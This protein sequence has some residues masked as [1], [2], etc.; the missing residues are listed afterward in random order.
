M[1][2]TNT[3]AS[4]EIEFDPPLGPADGLSHPVLRGAT[5]RWTKG[6]GSQRLLQLLKDGSN[7]RSFRVLVCTTAAMVGVPAFVMAVAYS[8]VLDRFF[9][10]GSAADKMVY[11]GIAGICAVQAVVIGFLVYAFREE[12]A[13]A[14]AS[15]P[16]AD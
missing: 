4:G 8:V 14:A 7:A 13:D 11:A 6:G 10:F 5:E 2:T 1:A 9:T 16:K 15:R 3:T 12:E